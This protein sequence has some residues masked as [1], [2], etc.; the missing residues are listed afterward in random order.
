MMYPEHL[1]PTKLN[2]LAI[3]L[4]FEKIV[5]AAKRLADI[6]KAGKEMG[7]HWVLDEWYKEQAKNS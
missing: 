3:A 7:L 1:K 2:V 5:N 4:T 6:I